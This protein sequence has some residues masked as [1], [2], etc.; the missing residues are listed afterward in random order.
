M[1][2]ITSISALKRKLTRANAEARTYLDEVGVLRAELRREKATTEHVRAQL[3]AK[4]DTSMIEA[5][6]KLMSQIGQALSG[7]CELGKFCIGKE[8]L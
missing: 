4:V 7:V 6:T 3:D 5:R 2:T 8:Q 1:K